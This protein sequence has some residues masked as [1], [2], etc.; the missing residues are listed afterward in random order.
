MCHS[1]H[2]QRP[3]TPS[4]PSTRSTVP[5]LLGTALTRDVQEQWQCTMQIFVLDVI[6]PG[7]LPGRG[8]LALLVLEFQLSYGR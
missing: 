4:K 8:Q 3:A 6:E 5:Q 7:G 1:F 2:K